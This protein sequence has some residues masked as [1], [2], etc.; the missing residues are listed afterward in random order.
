MKP[1]ETASELYREIK[2]RGLHLRD[3]NGRDSALL[4]EL[5]GKIGCPDTRLQKFLDASDFSAEFFLRIFLQ[6]VAPFARM[7]QEIWDYLNREGAPKATETIAVR[8]GFEDSKD[9]CSIDL[10]QFRRYVETAQHVIAAVTTRIWP[11]KAL[12]GLFGVAKL[13][14]L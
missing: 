11:Y 9:T 12:H 6:L 2:R 10:D 4:Q 7:F 8:F 5:G 3:E 14:T 1:I 13:G